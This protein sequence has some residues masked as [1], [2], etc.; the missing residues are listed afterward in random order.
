LYSINSGKLQISTL[1]PQIVADNLDKFKLTDLE[2]LTDDQILALNFSQLTSDQFIHLPISSYSW[3]L[4]S[5]IKEL[6]L[7][8]FTP[9]NIK[10]IMNNGNVFISKL[11]PQIVADNLDKFKLTH[12]KNLTDDQILALD[13][14]QLTS[15]Q[16][17]HLPISLYYW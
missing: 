8:S 11:S 15:D 2:N 5:L 1:S 9:K 14:A 10:K 12:L 13:F 7:Y 6:D 17:I 4:G 3:R 16:F